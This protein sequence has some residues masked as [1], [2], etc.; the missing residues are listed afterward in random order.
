MSCFNDTVLL[1][2]DDADDAEIAISALNKLKLPKLI[3]LDDGAI[4]LEYLFASSTKPPAVILLDLKMPK[5]D[6]IEILAKLKNDL[7]RK[8]IPVV[9]LISSKEGRKYVESFRLSPEGYLIKP[10]DTRNFV[11]VLR[12]IGL[13]HLVCATAV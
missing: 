8:N 11:S 12:E 1:I 10:I 2:E 3:H 5:V 9:A 4:A 6:G 7:A 13:A